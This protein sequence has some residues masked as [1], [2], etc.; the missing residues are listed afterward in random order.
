MTT[1]SSLP[2]AP[3][4]TDT[5]AAFN[6]KAF[7]LLAALSNF[8]TQT[9]AVA[10]ESQAS[11]TSAAASAATAIAKAVEAFNSATSSAD[12]AAIAIAKAN[13]AFSSATSS[14]DSA[15]TADAKA[16]EAFS[17]AASA[18]ASAAAAASSAGVAASGGIRYDQDQTLSSQ[19]KAQA[20][21]N[22]GAVGVSDQVTLLNKT[23]KTPLTEGV[24]FDKRV[25][26]S[27][28]TGAITLDLSAASV[29]EL[30]LSG[31][32]T[33]ITLANVPALTGGELS[34]VVR[35]SQGAT[36][37][38]LAWFSGVTWLTSGGTAPPV[39]LANKTIEYIFSS[40]A[41]GVYLGRKGAS[42]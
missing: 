24:A 19:Q 31:N 33:G 4:P 13:Q 21:S 3:S 34:F 30:T 11:A 42:T 9:N 12:N 39:P 41:A 17:N 25:T 18:A 40:S 1:I 8:V 37:F 29:F 6:S 20:I 22:L 23:L 14:A 15:A 2:D 35:V 10:G 36:A 16:I 26:N 38:S 32:V 28:A 5:T 7:A 27:S